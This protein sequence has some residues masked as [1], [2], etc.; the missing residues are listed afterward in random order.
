MLFL[1]LAIA[2]APPAHC[3]TVTVARSDKQVPAIFGPKVFRQTSINFE[4]A[5]AKACAEGLLK[6]RP[7]APGNKLFLTNAPEAN[8][9]SIYT[10]GRK[11]VIEYWFVTQDGKSHVPSVKELHEAIFCAVVGASDNEQEESGRCLPD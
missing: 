2:A 7:L 10:I 4:T 5:Y 3:A 9:A 6:K 1:L 11:A 8:D